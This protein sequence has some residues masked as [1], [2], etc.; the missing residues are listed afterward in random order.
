MNAAAHR[1]A[2][3]GKA[4]RAGTSDHAVGGC[5]ELQL[6]VRAALQHAGEMA[7]MVAPRRFCANAGGDR[8][9]GGG[10]TGM[11]VAADA[12]IG[13]LDGADDAGDAGRDEGVGAGPSAAVMRTG[14]KGDVAGGAAGEFPGL[15]KGQRFAVRAAALG[16]PAAADDQRSG[17]GVAHD[18]G[19]DGGIGPG[20]AEIAPADGERRTHEATVAVGI[21]HDRLRG[22]CG[23]YIQ[24]NASGRRAGAFS[25]CMELRKG[26]KPLICRVSGRRTGSHFAWKRS[27]TAIHSPSSGAPPPP[28]CTSSSRNSSK[29]LASRKSR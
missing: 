15:G 21:D 4:R 29:S 3:D 18:D 13:I 14:L 5:R 28:V 26:A 8:D 25:Q 20:L 24:L 22:L 1:L 7:G 17:R 27:G 10:E 12:R 16:G 9:A 2:G 11:A 6:D 23:R 19:T